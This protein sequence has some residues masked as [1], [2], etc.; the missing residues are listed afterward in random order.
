[1][2]GLLPDEFWR[3]AWP[4]YDDLLYHHRYQEQ[5]ALAGH[6]MVATQVYN[7][8]QG[9]ATTPKGKTE[10][11]YRSL[12]LID[13]PPPPPPPVSFWERIKNHATRAGLRWAAPTD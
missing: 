11:E 3:L 13:P 6:R 4:D 10:A 9:F 2:L 8:M 1:M 12:P 5:Q 7:A